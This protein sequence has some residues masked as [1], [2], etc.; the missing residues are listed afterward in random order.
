[1]LGQFSKAAVASQ[2]T[3]KLLGATQTLVECRDVGVVE[4]CG[5]IH[6]TRRWGLH[7]LGTELNLKFCKVALQKPRPVFGEASKRKV[8]LIRTSANDDTL[9]ILMSLVMSL[10][11][12]HTAAAVHIVECAWPVERTKVFQCC[13]TVGEV[14]LFENLVCRAWKSH[15]LMN[16]EFGIWGKRV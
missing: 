3:D 1:M 4:S 11:H 6:L 13:I 14:L 10:L 2:V 16:C 15:V 9:S 12:I 8:G 5:N 7:E